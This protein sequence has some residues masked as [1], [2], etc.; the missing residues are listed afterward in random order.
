MS[1]PFLVTLSRFSLDQNKS[2]SK[3][4]K[5][6]SKNE[7]KILSFRY[8]IIYLLLKHDEW[9]GLNTNKNEQKIK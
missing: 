6:V 1:Y 5:Y 7:M 8:K 2:K 9:W 3:N 4:F